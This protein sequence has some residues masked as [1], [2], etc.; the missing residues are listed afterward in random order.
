V[1]ARTR[2]ARPSG[3]RRVADP[4]AARA[5]D[6]GRRAAEPASV[7]LSAPKPRLVPGSDAVADDLVGLGAGLVVGAVPVAT[8]REPVR[9]AIGPPGFLLGN[10]AETVP[11]STTNT[12][13]RTPRTTR[14]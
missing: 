13:S 10:S 4:G 1:R 11:T 14:P 5:A 12:A 2:S 7:E 8:V 9:G 6:A 3:R